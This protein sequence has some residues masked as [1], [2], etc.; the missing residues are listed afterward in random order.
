[1]PNKNAN[2]YC[3]QLLKY[4]KFLTIKEKLKSN[5]LKFIS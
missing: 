4:G 2:L 5:P 1:M 3:I